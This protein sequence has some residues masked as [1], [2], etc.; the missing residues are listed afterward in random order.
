MAD[1]K[2]ISIEEKINE[3]LR[4]RA[5]ALTNINKLMGDQARLCIEMS[6]LCNYAPNYDDSVKSLDDLLKSMSSTND[7]AKKLKSTTE[8][9][10]KALEDASKEDEKLNKGFDE[11]EAA[12]RNV[13][14]TIDKFEKNVK[15]TKDTI[16]ETQIVVGAFALGIGQGLVNQFNAI[17]SAGKFVGQTFMTITSNVFQLGAS[18]L[19]IPFKILGG[20]VDMAQG[21]GGGNE[22]AQAR[23]KV[24]QQFGDLSKDIAKNV[25][26]SEKNMHGMMASGLRAF[27]VFGNRAEQLTYFTEMFTAMGNVAHLFG[28]EIAKQPEIIGQYAKGLGLSHEQMKFVGLEAKIAGAT[29]EDKLNEMTVASMGMAEKFGISHKLISRDIGDMMQD[30]KH[31]TSLTVHE[32]SR[33]SVYVR[34][35]GLEIKEVAGILDKF[36][37]F[38]DAAVATSNLSQAFGMT[39]DTME[40]LKEASPDKR[41]D[42]LRKSMAAAGQDAATMSRQELALLAANTG[43]DEATAK[44]AFSTKNQG[45]SMKDLEKQQEKNKKKTMTQEEAMGKLANSIE[46]LIKSGQSLK[47]GF[48]SMFAQGFTTGIQR[49]YPFRM[50]LRSLRRSLRVVFWAG[51][52][53]GRAFVESFPGVSKMIAAFREFFNPGRFRSLMGKIV[54]QFKMFFND[55]KDPTKA[56][57]AVGNLLT[58]IKKIFLEFFGGGSGPAQMFLDGFKNFGKALSNILAGAIRFAWSGIQPILS[59][60]KDNLSLRSKRREKRK[61]IAATV[62]KT[63]PAEERNKEIERQLNAAMGPDAGIFGGLFDGL[64]GAFSGAFSELASVFGEIISPLWDLFTDPSFIQEVKSVVFGFFAEVWNA[65]FNEIKEKVWEPYGNIII[66][67][68]I[69]WFAGGALVKGLSNAAGAAVGLAMKS[70]TESIFQ[71]KAVKGVK[72]AASAA[73]AVGSISE[74]AGAAVKSAEFTAADAKGLGFK[75]L[76]M[77]TAL[78]I[79]G[80]ML[81]V[82]LIAIYRILKA[83][84]IADPISAAVPLMVLVGAAAG[85]TALAFAVKLVQ[86]TDAQQI[87]S[88]LF[89]MG[90]ALAAGGV[91]FAASI[92]LMAAILSAQNPSQI[93]LALGVLVIGVGAMVGVGFA[94]KL[95]ENM[96]WKKLQTNIMALAVFLSLG[97]FIFAV[98][99]LAIANL[100]EGVKLENIAKALITIGT[101]VLLMLPLAL[102]MMLVSKIPAAGL[103]QA[104]PVLGTMVAVLLI[105]GLV[106]AAI[107]GLTSFIKNPES[108]TA[109]GELMLNMSLS[110]LAMVPVVL[111][112]I[113]IGAL[114]ANPFGVPALVVGMTALSAA[115]AAVSI[116]VFSILETLAGLQVDSTFSEKAHAFVEV[117]NSVN[118]FASTFAVI[119][120]EI[121]PTWGDFLQ[122]K[123]MA[124]LIN[125]GIEFINALVGSKENSTGILGVMNTV[126]QIIMQFAAEGSAQGI[127]KAAET[128]TSILNATTGL[129]IALKPDPALFEA[130]QEGTKGTLWDDVDIDF[131]GLKSILSKMSGELVSVVGTVQ[132]FITQVAPLVKDIPAESLNAVGGILG[133]IANIV[134]AIKP[135]PAV[136][137]QFKVVTKGTVTDTTVLDVTGLTVF[138][139]EYLDK[140]KTVLPAISGDIVNSIINAMGNVDL[141]KLAKLEAVSKILGALGDVASALMKGMTK[142]TTTDA[143]TDAKGK[144]KNVKQTVEETGDVVKV[145]KDMASQFG[146]MSSDLSNAVSALPNDKDFLK[147]L[148]VGVKL[149]AML[150]EIPKIL[151]SI[152]EA[153]TTVDKEGKAISTTLTPG[154]LTRAFGVITKFL[155]DIIKP[156]TSGK[157]PIQ[158]IITSVNTL[159][160]ELK[161]GERG[162]DVSKKITGVKTFMEALPTIASAFSTFISSDTK[163]ATGGEITK[164]IGDL[165][166][167]IDNLTGQGG[168][169][170]IDEALT[171]EHNITLAR[172]AYKIKKASES[173][174][175]IN[176]AL[177]GGGLKFDGENLQTIITS[178]EGIA[179]WTPKDEGINIKVNENNKMDANSIPV[180]Q[181]IQNMVK[182]A[183]LINNELSD[184]KTTTVTKK[185]TALGKSLGISNEKLTIKNDGKVNVHLNL[186][187][188]MDAGD[189]ADVLVNKTKYVSAGVIK[190]P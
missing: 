71:T 91:I 127:T 178:F 119:L 80:P 60:I 11:L 151:N 32:M 77:A 93:L 57:D 8:D 58:N 123:G 125:R 165:K 45:V 31:Y 116:A 74:N 173:I 110:L 152:K 164:K 63:L 44:L 187:V 142:K 30:T 134:S 54:D 183:N 174:T 161:L 20:L 52:R 43:L 103:S 75:L 114:L 49:A 180:V 156:D 141:E 56:K 85:M 2:D 185:L 160:K 132:T 155:A 136:L 145:M 17:V 159:G 181:Q 133:G 184:L 69:G 189:I 148:D 41:I 92:A 149:F 168:V 46:R 117:M 124:D 62:D 34:K 100:F 86:E 18:I 131:T 83:G 169:T 39:I 105:L 177:A 154:K 38:N 7:E 140:M 158:G 84:G 190:I 15:K 37:N 188:T 118:A 76:A 175:N 108:V 157:S 81:A 176:D 95:T 138:M 166:I 22:F 120:G 61:E 42:M 97:G 153:T 13:D 25:M 21:M 68:I 66:A 137:E 3:V 55:L 67:S 111:A 98:A 59:K 128:F 40:M 162:E 104:I 135:D 121:R 129:M 89:A 106:G 1:S 16:D 102:T 87:S 171:K 70:M 109:A 82:S 172:V 122:G 29:L 64:E 19:S 139:K 186:N 65:V 28:D 51:R 90:R 150:G 113:A 24:R 88:K 23:E 163:I 94:L 14:G 6:K 78:A 167:A 27:R 35:L 9:L 26:Q 126:T 72:D 147:K 50:M 130:I 146:P 53:L 144:L 115:M 5:V 47:G 112:S 33:A 12:L 101:M 96:D 107:A 179:N 4:Q 73:G 48:F 79:A 182:I 170:S 10:A 143:S 99:I 36:D